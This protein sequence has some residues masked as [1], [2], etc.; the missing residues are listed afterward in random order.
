MNRKDAAQQAQVKHLIVGIQADEEAVREQAERLGTGCTAETTEAAQANAEIVAVTGAS[1]AAR[2][3]TEIEQLAVEVAMQGEH[4]E[5]IA[6]TTAAGAQPLA[7]RAKLERHV[8]ETLAA[9]EALP[10]GTAFAATCAE[11]ELESIAVERRSKTHPAGQQAESICLE[12]KKVP[13]S[14]AVE[15][16]RFVQSHRPA[17]A[18][19]SRRLNDDRLVPRK[20]DAKRLVTRR[21]P[22]RKATLEEQDVSRMM[23]KERIMELRQRFQ[24]LRTDHNQ[25]HYKVG[26]LST[27]MAHVRVQT[28]AALEALDRQKAKR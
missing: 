12:D 5:E 9:E 28:A 18:L 3:Q 8:A 19:A 6:G 24:V 22:S 15:S 23:V 13:S 17:S 4:E 11:N 21:F 10:I 7:A 20:P 1:E 16:T 26:Q 2:A 25:I 14:S 27:D